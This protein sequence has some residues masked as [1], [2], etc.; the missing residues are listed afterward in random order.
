MKKDASPKLLVPL[1]EEDSIPT[2]Y[3]LL[4]EVSRIIDILL[5]ITNNVINYYYYINILIAG[6]MDERKG[7]LLRYI[8]HHPAF[9]TKE[10]QVELRSQYHNVQRFLKWLEEVGVIYKHSTVHSGSSGAPVSVYLV[11]GA[12]DS[13]VERAR[14][15][16]LDW[17]GKPDIRSYDLI[18]VEVMVDE[19][20]GQLLESNKTTYSKMELHGLLRERKEIYNGDIVELLILKLKENGKR[21]TL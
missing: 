20:L 8:A 13:H 14:L 3:D 1:D 19:V 4:T 6:F 17:V 18:Q 12:D 21:V 7:G 9:T 5:L 2:P 15:F 10:L 16:Y 11:R